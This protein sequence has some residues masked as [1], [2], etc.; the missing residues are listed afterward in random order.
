MILSG[1]SEEIIHG[2]SEAEANKI[3]T[4]LHAASITAE[5]VKEPDGF[6]AISVTKEES[7]EALKV[8]SE[9]RLLPE[10]GPD[11]PSSSGV[12]SSREDQKFRLERSISRELEGTL[13][14]IPGVLESRVHLNLPPTDPLFGRTISDDKG[15]AA[16]LLVLNEL[17]LGREEVVA[18]VSGA[19]GIEKTQ[20]SVVMNTGTSSPIHRQ[21]VM[22]PSSS[23]APMFLRP[24]NEDFILGLAK[25]T[26]IQIAVS[27]FIIGFGL[28]WLLFKRN[29]FKS[30]HTRSR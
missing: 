11:T 26:I 20:I 1:C 23:P 5:K 10:S 2:L 29:N 17:T 22:V 14:N 24:R 30:M 28:L 3:L 19:S 16:V 13:R 18:L 4:G 27:L 6:W 7:L 15:S 12:L 21:Q 8:L 25:S 9:S